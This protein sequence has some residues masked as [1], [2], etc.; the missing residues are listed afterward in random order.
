MRFLVN[1]AHTVVLILLWPMFL[2]TPLIRYNLEYY[3]QPLIA[4]DVITAVYRNSYAKEMIQIRQN[5]MTFTLCVV[6]ASAR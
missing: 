3:K 4:G 1:L 6:R 5:N 2:L